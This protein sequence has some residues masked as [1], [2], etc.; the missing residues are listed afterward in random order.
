[1]PGFTIQTVPNG[2][3]SGRLFVFST[4]TPHECVEAMA[5][6]QGAIASA[7]RCL[8][9]SRR[10]ERVQ[11]AAG[12][13]VESTLVRGLVGCAI[14]ATWMLSILEAQLQPQEGSPLASAFMSVDNFLT[15]FFLVE[16][17]VNITAFWFW[18]FCSDGW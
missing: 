7:E 16:L 10:I 18:R 5:K 14:F 15:F 11:G 12:R 9:S 6:S 2:H 1:M 3:N 8:A 13:V 4:D 17:V